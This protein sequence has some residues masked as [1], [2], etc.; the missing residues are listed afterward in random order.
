MADWLR[1][2]H[3]EFAVLG[4]LS[5][6]SGRIIPPYDLGGMQWEW[7]QTVVNA[8]CAA[9]CK[10]FLKNIA[11]AVWANLTNPRTGNCFEGPRELRELPDEWLAL[12]R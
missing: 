2:F 11:S 9:G 5:D 6:G 4:G 8:T 7:A 3:V 12:K 1:R 10:V